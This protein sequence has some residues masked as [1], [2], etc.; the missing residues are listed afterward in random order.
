MCRSGV[1]ERAYA[2]AAVVIMLLEAVVRV[3]QL[4]WTLMPSPGELVTVLVLAVTLSVSF[5][6]SPAFHR[7]RCICIHLPGRLECH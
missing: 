6:V 1:S 2:I 5:T 3:T 7:L 4:D